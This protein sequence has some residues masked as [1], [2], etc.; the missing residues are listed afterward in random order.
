MPAMKATPTVF[1]FY[2]KMLTGSVCSTLSRPLLLFPLLRVHFLLQCHEEALMNQ[3]IELGT[4][5]HML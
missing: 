3:P 5:A 2:F 1:F 4:V